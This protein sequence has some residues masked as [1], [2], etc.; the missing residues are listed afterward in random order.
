MNKKNDLTAFSKTIE[1]LENAE[2][3]NTTS[4]ERIYNRLVYKL[5]HGAIT[6]QSGKKDG[7]TMKKSSWRTAVVIGSAVICLGGAFSA[8]SYAQEMF[9]SIMAKFEVGN[10]KITQ[11]DKEIPPA[12]STFTPSEDVK[13]GGASGV[14]KLPVSAKLTLDEARAALGMNF[15][16][17]GWMA[18]YEYVNSV[19]QGE[20]MVEVQYNSGEKAVN[21][22]ISKGGENGISTT[23]EVS[24]EVING[25]TVYYANGIVIWEKDGFTVELYSQVDFDKATLE[26]IIGSFN[27]GAPVQ[28]LG[29]D[30]VKENLQN[31][32]AAVAAPA[33]AVE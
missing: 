3:D 20:S 26:K 17:P 14:I 21:F 18:D 30:E 11:Y 28:S 29:A 24:T 7:I 13:G 10:L 31:S 23:E 12:A 19:L 5:D 8:T 2:P 15:P 6:P 33:P 9:Q 32:G 1:L 22:L 16:A 4:K 27:I 25:T